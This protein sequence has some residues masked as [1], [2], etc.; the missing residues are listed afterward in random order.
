MNIPYTDFSTEFKK[1]QSSYDSVSDYK[2]DSCSLLIYAIR[3]FEL[4]VDDVLSLVDLNVA[5]STLSDFFTLYANYSMF[6]EWSDTPEQLLDI[7]LHAEQTLDAQIIYSSLIGDAFKFYSFKTNLSLTQRLLDLFPDDINFLDQYTDIFNPTALAN[8][9]YKKV[10]LDKYDHDKCLRLSDYRRQQF[11]NR[12]AYERYI[13]IYSKIL[14]G[15][16]SQTFSELTTHIK[17]YLDEDSELTTD[18]AIMLRA[19]VS[20]EPLFINTTDKLNLF[21]YGYESSLLGDYN[22]ILKLDLDKLFVND[23][24]IIQ[25]MQKSSSFKFDTIDTDFGSQFW[26]RHS[27]LFETELKEPIFVER[28]LRNIGLYSFELI[29]KSIL[30]NTD[31]HSL[32]LAIINSY[33]RLDDIKK[34]KLGPLFVYLILSGYDKFNSEVKNCIKRIYPEI[35]TKIGRYKL[36]KNVLGNENK[37]FL[38]HPDLFSKEA[39][40]NYLLTDFSPSNNV[41]LDTSDLNFI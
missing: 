2:S 1:L 22:D 25:M 35:S 18:I 11:P 15:L 36:I 20:K 4:T 38:E 17:C 8:I 7:M 10:L 24:F 21:S 37:K 28:I 12:C 23:D 26:N 19:W 41:V 40:V 5:K 3:K 13:E 16:D 27:D 33:S 9:V 31:Y 6:K 29:K 39:A 32:T 14:T 30:F 34:S